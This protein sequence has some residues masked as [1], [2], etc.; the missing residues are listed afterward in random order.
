[1]HRPKFRLLAHDTDAHHGRQ[2]Q[3]LHEDEPSLDDA[4]RPA[5]WRALRLTARGL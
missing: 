1:M 4:S 5:R 3:R 2:L